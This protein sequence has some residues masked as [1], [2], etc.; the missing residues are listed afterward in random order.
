MG[1]RRKSVVA[2]GFDKFMRSRSNGASRWEDASPE[3]VFEWLCFLDSQGSGTT[4]EHATCAPRWDSVLSLAPT[5]RSAVRGVMRLDHC[6]SHSYS[7]L[8]GQTW[9]Y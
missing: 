7:S 6:R 9:K 2:D 8:S 3:M 4:I 1:Q 5:A